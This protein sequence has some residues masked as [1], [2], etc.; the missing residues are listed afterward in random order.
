MSD[1]KQYQNWPNLVLYTKEFKEWVWKLFRKVHARIGH[2]EEDLAKAKSE[3]R[4]NYQIVKD[5][6]DESLTY[7]LIEMETGSNHGSIVFDPSSGI[8]P[9]VWDDEISPI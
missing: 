9:V 3:L 6:D 5:Q 2:V 4:T 1:T 8:K 7:N